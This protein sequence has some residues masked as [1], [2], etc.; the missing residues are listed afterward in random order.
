MAGSK[1]ASIEGRVAAID[2]RALGR[3]LDRSGFARIPGLLT[4]RECGQLAALYA[5]PRHFRKRVE[6]ERHGFGV[7]EY[8]YFAAPLPARVAALRRA[9]YPAL[10]RI[11]NEWQERLRAPGRFPAG[12]PAFLR[13]CAAAGQAQP[14]PLML[15]Y[16]A[17]GYNRLHQ[18]LYGTLA[19]PL[20]LTLLLSR[21]ERDF[22]GGEFL[23]LERRAR[24]QSRADAIALCQGEAI[25][26]PTRERPVAS[27]RG[28]A[29]AEMRHGVSTVRRGRRLALGV[30]FHDAKS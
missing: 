1:T 26:F 5:V 18:D 8:Q 11:A 28:F 13:D 10:A 22:E 25:V 6:M 21:P 29:R 30:I 2:A 24:M 16:E 23:L 7:G 15:R 4:P 20:Q 14:T 27:A 17:G 19:F 3:E 12:L 9:L